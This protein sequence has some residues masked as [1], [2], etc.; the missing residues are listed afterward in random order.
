[1]YKNKYTY[2]NKLLVGSNIEIWRTPG[3]L[4]LR[5]P[6][7]LNLSGNDCTLLFLIFE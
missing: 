6:R 3:F 2:T 7:R 1:M 5:R 4:L